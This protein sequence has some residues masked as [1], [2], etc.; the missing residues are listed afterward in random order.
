MHGY[1]LRNVRP[2]FVFD[3]HKSLI[4]ALRRAGGADEDEDVVEAAEAKFNEAQVPVTAGSLGDLS[5]GLVNT[6]YVGSQA[7]NLVLSELDCVGR[8]AVA[9]EGEVDPVHARG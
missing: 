9:N 3:P 7:R 5:E 8:P 1:K 6:L 2:T 4:E